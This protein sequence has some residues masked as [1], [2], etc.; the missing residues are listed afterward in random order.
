MEVYQYMS[1]GGWDRTYVNKIIIAF[2][3]NELKNSI[4]YWMHMLRIAL[5]N[6]YIYTYI[7]YITNEPSNILFN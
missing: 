7:I 5:N 3:F 2:Y 6:G 1:N 4:E